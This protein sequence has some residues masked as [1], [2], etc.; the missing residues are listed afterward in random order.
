MALVF[1]SFVAYVPPIQRGLIAANGSSIGSGILGLALAAGA[2]LMI[3]GWC[4]AVWLALHESRERTVPKPIT[5]LLLL[6]GNVIAALVY[7]FLVSRKAPL[8][9]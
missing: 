4:G 9:R 8:A 7:H 1:A 2:A 3:A 6:A 5:V